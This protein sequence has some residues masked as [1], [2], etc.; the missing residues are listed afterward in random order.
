MS[1][2]KW[3]PLCLGLNVSPPWDILP[4]FNKLPVNTWRPRQPHFADGIFK[5]IF[6][7]ENYRILLRI[8]MQFVLK[9]PISSKPALAYL[10]A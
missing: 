8:S 9:G 2:A 3:R 7:T 6:S 10:M 5:P 4:D 1:S